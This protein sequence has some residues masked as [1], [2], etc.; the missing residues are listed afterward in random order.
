MKIFTARD[1]FCCPR[2]FLRCTIFYS[3]NKKKKR[4]KLFISKCMQKVQSVHLQMLKLSGIQKTLLYW[5]KTM[6]LTGKKK[7]FFIAKILPSGSSQINFFVFPLKEK[8]FHWN[9]FDV[10]KYEE[11]D[12]I[13]WLGKD[14]VTE[15]IYT[16]ISLS[17]QQGISFDPTMKSN[18]LFITALGFGGV[19]YSVENTVRWQIHHQGWSRR[20]A[21]R[22]N[23]SALD[24]SVSQGESKI[25]EKW[26]FKKGDFF[27]K[28]MMPFSGWHHPASSQHHFLPAQPCWESLNIP[29][30]FGELGFSSLGSQSCRDHRICLTL[31][32][33][34]LLTP[35]LVR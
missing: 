32:N 25:H 2:D 26:V 35:L 30:D 22:G 15:D 8:L 5:T 28:Q 23:N 19:F 6:F 17:A 20:G 16:W 18:A 24:S 4:K 11:C 13:S 33:K 34:S 7:L 10:R 29:K 12:L 9:G 14:A 27:F 31:L 3:K 1:E 21:G